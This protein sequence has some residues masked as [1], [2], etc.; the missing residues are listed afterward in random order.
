MVRCALPLI[1]LSL[2]AALL[3]LAQNSSHN[4][5]TAKEFRFEVVSLKPMSPHG[6]IYSGPTGNPNPSP[7][8]FVSR[9]SIFQLIMLAYAPGDYTTW[10]GVKTRNFPSWSGAFYD[11]NARVAAVDLKAWQHQG[12]QNELLRLAIQAVLKDRCKLAVHEEPSK[13]ED[14]ELVVG[15]HG[16][17]LQAA[18]PGFAD[19]GFKPP[20][21]S[22][23]SGGGVMGQEVISGKEVKHFYGATMVDLAEL[24]VVLTRGVPVYD[25]THLTGRYDFMLR[26]QPP[27]PD[28]VPADPDYFLSKYPIDH[29]GLELKRGI[30]MRPMLVIDHID[31]PTAN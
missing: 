10:G 30:E 16:P 14:W 28:S 6:Q 22:K 27:P 18:A 7:N 19:P 24:L 3:G 25:R 21:A 4:A 23:L 8:G 1:A 12:R 13:A 31:K 2:T 17:R 20:N 9:L 26:E 15:K 5:E 11:V 29:L